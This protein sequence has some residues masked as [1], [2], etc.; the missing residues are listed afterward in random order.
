MRLRRERLPLGRHEGEL[1][2]RQTQELPPRLVF[3]EF[4]HHPRD[5]KHVD[6]PPQP[7]ASEGEK[8]E[9]TR[10]RTVEIEA[11]AAEDTCH[12]PQRVGDGFALRPVAVQLVEHRA[13]EV[14]VA[15]PGHARR[16]LVQRGYPQEGLVGSPGA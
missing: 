14:E 2:G 12:E 8:H 4:P 1:A 5:Q 7:P 10:S 6:E 13:R 11:V 16:A 15:S 3:V 9:E